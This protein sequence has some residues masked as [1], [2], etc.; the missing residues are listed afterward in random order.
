MF[1]SVCKW[2]DTCL[3]KPFWH[4]LLSLSAC[5]SADE[6]YVPPEACVLHHLRCKKGGTLRGP[7]MSLPSPQQ[8]RLPLL[9]PNELHQRNSANPTQNI[10]YPSHLP[11]RLLFQISGP[12]W[13]SYY[14]SP[15]SPPIPG[16]SFNPWVFLLPPHLG[17]QRMPIWI[18]CRSMPRPLMPN[19]FLEL[20]CFPA[21]PTLPPPPQEIVN[22][23]F[24]PPFPGPFSCSFYTSVK[25]PRLE[26]GN[27][28]YPNSR[29]GRSASCRS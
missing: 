4:P 20:T 14:F 26:E 15:R 28:I 19:S 22:S 18:H 3:L 7:L 5:I 21:F 6:P 8:T 13:S 11:P 16:F 27:K 2:L 10:P 25:P 9:S 12:C 24:P 23:P 17:S 1:K 29:Y